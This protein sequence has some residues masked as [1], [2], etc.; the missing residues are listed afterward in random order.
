MLAQAAS[1]GKVRVP[2]VLVQ[3]EILTP[4]RLHPAGANG[5]FKIEAPVVNLSPESQFK[6]PAFVDAEI[7]DAADKVVWKGTRDLS[8]G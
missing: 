1:K 6:R 8:P 2:P 4:L 7:R 3:F 5:D